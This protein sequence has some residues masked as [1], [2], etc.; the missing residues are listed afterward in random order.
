MD[1]TPIDDVDVACMQA[2]ERAYEKFAGDL[3][4]ERER[5]AAAR[6]ALENLG[7]FVRK[8]NRALQRCRHKSEYENVERWLKWA[9][10]NSAGWESTGEFDNVD[11]RRDAPESEPSAS[12]SE[13]VADDED[14][15]ERRFSKYIDDEAASGDDD[16]DD[17]E[18]EEEE[19]KG[20]CEKVTAEEANVP[21]KRQRQGSDG[22][23]EGGAA[24]SIRRYFK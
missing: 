2:T 7:G 1:D 21:A 8:I 10:E 5:V 17:D 9:I 20:S 24:V 3:R 18:E 19:D 14:E 6:G 22:K 15:R 23:R 16:D 13:E 11:F 12:E 4:A